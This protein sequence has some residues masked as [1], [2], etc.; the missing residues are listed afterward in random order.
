MHSTAAQS[1]HPDGWDGI[2]E[3]DETLLWQDRPDGAFI[4]PTL[5]PKSLAPMIA[6]CGFSLFWMYQ[7]AQSGGYF[8]LLGLLIFGA[9]ISTLFR[10]PLRN[11]RL[12][13]ASWYS[14]SNRRAFIATDNKGQRQLQS[15]DIHPDLVLELVDGTPG[16]VYF[17]TI[18]INTS[19]GSSRQKVG[20]ERIADA[21]RIYDMLR[22]I[23]RGQ[24]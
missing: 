19:K 1:N 23:Q 16:S 17:D 4:W 13:R 5:T 22:K 14:L 6:I 9:G 2:L 8:W 20:F 7:A 21:R 24:A 3:A 10:A 11:M 12:R 15:Y 18:F